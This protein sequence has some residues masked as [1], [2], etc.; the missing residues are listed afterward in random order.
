MSLVG[1][2]AGGIVQVFVFTRLWLWIAPD[3]FKNSVLKILMMYLS[4][5]LIAYT[6]GIPVGFVRMYGELSLLL[7]F[8]VCF[9]VFLYDLRRL[10]R[11]R[12]LAD[13][14]QRPAQ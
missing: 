10:E 13:P 7:Y 8:A 4:Y 3:K 9:P 1:L 5:G 11:A 12:R 2:L 6:L 14:T